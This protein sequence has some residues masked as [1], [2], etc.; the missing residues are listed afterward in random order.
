M[1]YISEFQRMNECFIYFIALIDTE[2]RTLT[3]SSDNKLC[4]IE[5]KYVTVCYCNITAFSFAKMCNFRHEPLSMPKQTCVA[6]AEATAAETTKTVATGRYKR[7]CCICYRCFAS[8]ITPKINEMCQVFFD[9]YQW[10]LTYWS[11]SW[12]PATYRKFDKAKIIKIWFDTENKKWN[13]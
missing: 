8:R 5:Y 4:A 12:N 13:L 10:V 6:R 11:R 3:A 2:N 1:N 7:V 9:L